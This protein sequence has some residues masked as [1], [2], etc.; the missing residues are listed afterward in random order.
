MHAQ[1]HL[2]T[3]ERSARALVPRLAGDATGQIWTVDD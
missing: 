2:I 1:G 3:P